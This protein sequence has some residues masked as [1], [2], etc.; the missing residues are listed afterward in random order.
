MICVTQHFDLKGEANVDVL[1]HQ[2]LTKPDISDAYLNY[3]KCCLDEWQYK[4]YC[5]NNMKEPLQE[6]VTF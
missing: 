2:V 1:L 6:K 3:H 4:T 5:T